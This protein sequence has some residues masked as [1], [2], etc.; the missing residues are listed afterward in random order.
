MSEHNFIK[1]RAPGKIILSGEHAVVYGHPALAMAINR[2]TESIV[3]WS[4]PLHFRF[5]LL[6][7]DYR[8]EVT[9]ETLK[10]LKRK[11]QKQY[12]QFKSG[13]LNIREVLKH[14][15]ELSL[16]TAINL[17]E[18]VK[19]KLPMGIEFD[20]NSN[21]PIGCGLGSSASSVV[22][23][24]T[25]LGKLLEIDMTLEDYSRLAV[26]SENLQHGVSS[27]LDVQ[28]SYQGG[29]IFYQ[30]GKFEK[31]PLPQIPITLV[32]TGPP[33]SSTGEC[34]TKA[35][36]YFEKENLGPEFAAITKNLDSAIQAN[37]LAEIKLSI[38][39]NQRLLERIGVVSEKAKTFIRKIEAAG[40]SAKVCG[41]GGVNEDEVGAILVIDATELTEL[42]REFGYQIIPIKGDANGATVL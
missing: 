33:T 28:V 6:G 25:A 11:L 41:S 24:I 14:P 29:A 18:K 19:H 31:R 20:T 36:P 3:R 15:F 16:Y 9:L 22:S 35:K 5:N 12:Q 2:Y 13:D 38:Q 17:L 10:R 39:Q 1:A 21:I 8:Q 40:A 34:V 27:G 32:N 23:L 7:I 4:T 42:A 37:D 30:Q 26:E